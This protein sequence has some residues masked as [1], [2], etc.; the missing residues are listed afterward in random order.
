MIEDKGLRAVLIAGTGWGA[1]SPVE[2]FSETVYADVTLAADAV[3]PLP[4]E[5]EDRAVYLLSGAIEIGG[6]R[7][8]HGSLLV[9]RPG[10]A[11]NVRA[12]T[13]A[14][15]QVLGGATMDGSRHIWWNFVSSSKDRIEQAKADWKAGRFDIVPGDDEEFIPLPE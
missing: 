14:R 7:F 15:L 10:D 12:L 5:H 11:V 2:V 8:E 13:D 3:L 6:E 4:D 9:M 1:R